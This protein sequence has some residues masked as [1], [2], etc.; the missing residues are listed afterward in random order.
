M[1]TYFVTDAHLGSLAFTDKLENEKKLVRW[2]DSI[3]TDCEALYL[4]GDIMDFWFE[5]KH[6]VPK[7]FTRFFGK[8]AEFTDSGISVFW[9]AGNHDV[10]LFDYVQSELGVTVYDKPV[11]KIL[12]GKKFYLAHGDGL[13]D[14]SIRFKILR[15]VFHNRIC[16]RL[17]ASL[18]PGI[19]I[20]IGLAWAKYSRIK[21][22]GNPEYY[23]GENKEFLIRFS[24]KLAAES[25]ENAAS[26][27]VFGH[28]HIIVNLKISPKSKVVI[29]GDW[30]YLFSYGVFDGEYFDILTYEENVLK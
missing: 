12:H 1:R 9:I 30:I 19:G 15:A 5:Y 6:V 13:G 11:E 7:G 20:G 24:K 16:Q 17:F 27:Y 2:M 23:H 8:I 4:M 29:L 3:K 10:W 26:F 14:P 28:R 25:G 22:S 18:H 21:R